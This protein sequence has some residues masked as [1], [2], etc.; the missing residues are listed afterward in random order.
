MIRT[1]RRFHKVISNPL[2]DGGCIIGPNLYM[3]RRRKACVSL[4]R[5]IYV[6]VTILD[7]AKIRM[8]SFANIGLPKA[9]KDPENLSRLD[10]CQT[11][12]GKKKKK[13]NCLLA[14]KQA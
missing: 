9:M 1:E 8:S 7:H 13:M 11:D 14:G 4:N 3:A 2:F 12:T 6:G 10:I 5:P